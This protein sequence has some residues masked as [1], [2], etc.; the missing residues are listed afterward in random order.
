[1]LQKIKSLL[2][3]ILFCG[4][5]FA[6]TNFQFEF[7]TINNGQV[8]ETLNDITLV[9]DLDTLLNLSLQ[10]TGIPNENLPSGFSA[11]NISNEGLAATTVT[12]SQPVDVISF[13]L[14]AIITAPTPTSYL[15]TPIGGTGNDT[16]IVDNQPIRSSTTYFHQ[17]IIRHKKSLQWLN[18]P[19]DVV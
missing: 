4:I 14:I 3:S 18:Q 10:G 12:F 9:V 11:C 2:F 7:G 19:S 16:Y 5:S 17:I 8:T 15:I 13:F 6:Q 1:M